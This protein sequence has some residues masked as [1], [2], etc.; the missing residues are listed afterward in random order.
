MLPTSPDEQQGG[1][2]MTKTQRLRGII[3]GRYSSVSGLARQLDWGR[4]KLQRIIS[5]QQIPTVQEVYEMAL[6]LK[7]TL[8]EMADF[9]LEEKIT[10]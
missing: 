7:L 6:A 4:Q 10:K 8:S 3:C 9:F 2:E 5:G 1:S